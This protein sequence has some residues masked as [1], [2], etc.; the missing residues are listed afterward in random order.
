MHV[1]LYMSVYIYIYIG[2]EFAVFIFLSI[3]YCHY[4]NMSVVDALGRFLL[5][6]VYQVL[7]PI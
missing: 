1:R 6:I 4:K 5:V 7:L 3:K 2:T